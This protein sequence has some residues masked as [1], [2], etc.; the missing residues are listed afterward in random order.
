MTR[1]RT[2]IAAAVLV[3]L[4]LSA[5]PAHAG[6]GWW[7]GLDEGEAVSLTNV[8]RQPQEFRGRTLTF[9]CVLYTAA[10]DY[11][12]YPP[13]TAFTESNF[14]NFSAWADGTAVWEKE[15]FV[16]NFPFLYLRRTNSQRDEL[17]RMPR[18]T[19]LECTGRI[20]DIVRGRPAIEVFSFRET[21]HRLGKPIVDSILWGMNYAKHG[22]R[23]G[24]QNAARRF[25]EALQPDL[26]PVY[27]IVVRKYLADSLR[28][29]GNDAEADMYERGETVGT[30][31]LPRGDPGNAPGMP[32]GPGEEFPDAFPQPPSPDGSADL[33]AAPLG[34]ASGL[35]DGPP[36]GDSGFPAALPKGLPAPP[37][38][39]FLSD[40]LPGKAVEGGR[41]SLNKTPES[42]LP[43]RGPASRAAPGRSGRAPAGKPVSGIPP[44]RRPRLS[45]VK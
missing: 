32:M 12:Y 27:A 17:V 1:V 13:N 14:I 43:G 30:P 44:K 23:D 31:P 24:Y 7:G 5:V 15:A 33:P 42:E 37:A 21:G 25:K 3:A 9:Y 28:A 19:R 2:A 20:R 4:C 40:D 35:P 39:P 10:G 26:P 18:F 38:N 16:D 22:T 34:T 8:L 36:A 41:G 29:L 11:K 45:G 6:D